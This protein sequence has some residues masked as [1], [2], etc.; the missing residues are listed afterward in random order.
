MPFSLLFIVC[1]CVGIPVSLSLIAY[2]CSNPSSN[3]TTIS[4]HST[5]SCTFTP[6]PSKV[7][8]TSGQILQVKNHDYQYYQQCLVNVIQ[9]ISGCTWNDH[10]F[11]QRN[12]IV[13]YVQEISRQDCQRM[14]AYREYHVLDGMV[15]TGLQSNGT[16]KASFQVKGTIEQG[17]NCQG[18]TFSYRG[19]TYNKALMYK[20]FTV[21]LRDGIGNLEKSSGLLHLPGSMSCKATDEY[22]LDY[23]YGYTY[24]KLSAFLADKSACNE[25]NKD[26]VYAGPITIVETNDTDG[27]KTVAM[28]DNDE[29]IAALMI[30]GEVSECG[31]V[32]HKTDHP[33]IYIDLSSKNNRLYSASVL[34]SL[35]V[36]PFKYFNTKIVYYE[37]KSHLKNDK[38]YASIKY[39]Q[40]LNRKKSLDN[41]LALGM[42]DGD[43][44]AY[45]YMNGPGFTS[46]VSGEV[47]H[48]TQCTPTIVTTRSTQQFCFD[49]APVYLNISGKQMPYF[50]KPRTRVLT[51]VGTQRACNP[52]FPVLYNFDN[53]WYSTYPTLTE[54]KDPIILDPNIGSDYS[55]DHFWNLLA[56]GLYSYDDTVRFLA[57]AS[58]GLTRGPIMALIERKV[59]QEEIAD[60][61]LDTKGLLPNM[62]KTMDSWW[63]KRIETV[64]GF[65]AVAWRAAESCMV[66]VFIGYVI[67]LIVMM[68]LRANMI[69]KAYGWTWKIILCVNATLTHHTLESHRRDFH[70]IQGEAL[71]DLSRQHIKNQL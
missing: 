10:S 22:C 46:Q 70:M 57:M 16:I 47:I 43:Q 32:L 27:L 21:T 52:L 6:L 3:I 28:V 69:F 23:T 29:V 54:V 18:V 19:S 11:N 14:H 41:Q 26:E 12:A 55:L 61:G 7:S 62:E 17:G 4:L 45:V 8:I 71:V 48:I 37:R 24:W 9:H 13:T 59:T 42:I 53:R 39:E 50:M 5:K 40:C 60:Q 66:L 58:N 49:E 65:L 63:Q 51:P 38:I 33:A 15:M 31:R 2:D 25:M 35:D 30:T 68:A 36:D 44:F 34:H 64:W 56:A 20:E 1:I 67:K